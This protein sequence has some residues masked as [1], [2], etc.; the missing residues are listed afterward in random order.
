MSPPKEDD[1][2]GTEV[3]ATLQPLGQ[4]STATCLKLPPLW[5]STTKNSFPFSLSH[6][7]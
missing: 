4:A 1:R 5:G 2:G 7:I 6:P 3:T